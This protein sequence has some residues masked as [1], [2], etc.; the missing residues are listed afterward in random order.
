MERIKHIL[1]FRSDYNFYTPRLVNIILYEKTIVF[2]SLVR[3]WNVIFPTHLAGFERDI[4][5]L[6]ACLALFCR[7]INSVFTVSNYYVN[8]NRN[9]SLFFLSIKRVE[10]CDKTKYLKS[11]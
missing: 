7:E 5:T 1:E 4:T 10:L 8:S 9:A 3:C 11:T 2:Y 6:P